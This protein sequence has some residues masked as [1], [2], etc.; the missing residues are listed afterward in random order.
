M[1]P[2]KLRFYLHDLSEFCQIEMYGHFSESDISELSG[3]CATVKTILNSRKLV[4]DVRR[5]SSAD[6][7]AEEWLRMMQV[8]GAE[9]VRTRINAG[10][11]LGFREGAAY[12]LRLAFRANRGVQ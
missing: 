3:C 1:R 10:E 2:T 11:A 4:I 9:V 5:L 7:P 6:A 12:L 8:Q